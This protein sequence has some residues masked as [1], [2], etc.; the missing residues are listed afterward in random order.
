LLPDPA[1]VYATWRK[2]SAWK[3]GNGVDAGGAEAEPEDD[4]AAWPGGALPDFAAAAFRPANLDSADLRERL[5]A[6][7]PPVDPVIAT[8]LWDNPCWMSF[9]INFLA[10]AFNGPVYG[11]IEAR[12][13]I[14]RS[15]FVVLYSLYLKDGLAAKDVVNSTGFPKNTISRSIQ[16][17]LHRRLIRRAEDASDRRSFVLRLTATGRALVADFMAPMIERERVMLAT[18]TPAERLTLNE[19]LAKMIVDSPNWPT[20]SHLQEEQ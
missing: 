7:G 17:L 9:R 1:S 19:L 13:G 8:K 15:E 5:A 6:A 20:A 14:K 18:L 2:R 10:L 3:V 11:L 16:T 4:A 12:S